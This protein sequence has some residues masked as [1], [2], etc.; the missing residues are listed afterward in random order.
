[1]SD[2]H[3]LSSAV[4]E[5]AMHRHLDLQRQRIEAMYNRHRAL[6]AE[7][8]V[9]ELLGAE[10]VVD[11]TNAW[12]LS[13]TTP[14]GRPVR[15]QVK[16]SGGFLPR[17]AHREAESPA[18]WSVKEPGSGW[19]DHADPEQQRLGP[20]HHCDVFVLA[21]HTGTGISRGWSFAV[22]PTYLI[23]NAR[24]K[25]GRPRREVTLRHLGGWGI[26]LVE[27]DELAATVAAAVGAQFLE[28]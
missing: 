19:Q 3:G 18:K 12:D 5:A 2:E 21:R 16:C 23:E 28:R 17:Y 22:V 7:S 24:T 11:P 15:I 9:A 27:P 13:W 1:M 25:A 8:L 26:S 14:D 4:Y 20:G 10:E 6:F